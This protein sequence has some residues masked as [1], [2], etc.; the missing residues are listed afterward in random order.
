[1]PPLHC[2]FQ[3]TILDR[4]TV[5]ATGKYF[6]LFRAGRFCGCN[7]TGF[8]QGG[9][10]HGPIIGVT[11]DRQVR[12]VLAEIRFNFPN[13]AETA[14]L[15]ASAEESRNVRDWV[16]AGAVTA[17]ASAAINSLLLGKNRE[18]HQYGVSLSYSRV[19]SF[20]LIFEILGCRL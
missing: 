16:V 5:L 4:L 19:P 15:L 17:N 12:E 20:P 3:C 7:P 18:I 14:P 2:I 8:A 11:T 13:L 1:M 6:V 9:D 10:Q